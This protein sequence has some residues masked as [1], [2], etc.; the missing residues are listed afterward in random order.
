MRLHAT[1][2]ETGGSLE[3]QA[4]R[5]I[6]PMAPTKLIDKAPPNTS[7][8]YGFGGVIVAR[9]S[10]P[11]SDLNATWSSYATCRSRPDQYGSRSLFFRILPAPETGSASR[12]STLRGH[13]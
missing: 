2:D 9:A 4:T 10:L 12:N 3:A 1:P 11:A 8:R 5:R 7:S 13:L 6:V